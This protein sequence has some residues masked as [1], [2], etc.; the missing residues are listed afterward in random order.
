MICVALLKNPGGEVGE[1]KGQWGVARLG[2]LVL[3][4]ELIGDVQSARHAKEAA[5]NV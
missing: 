1:R 5:A 2:Q 3:L 4:V